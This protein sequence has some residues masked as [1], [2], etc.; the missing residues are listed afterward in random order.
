MNLSWWCELG[1]DENLGQW[2]NL[3]EFPLFSWG[4]TNKDGVL[5]F[6]SPQNS[7][8]RSCVLEECLL[9]HYYKILVNLSLGNTPAATPHFRE[10]VNSWLREKFNAGTFSAV[11]P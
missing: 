3:A 7:A 10:V 4:S 1:G 11:L 2:D 6:L 9:G 5:H 8:Q